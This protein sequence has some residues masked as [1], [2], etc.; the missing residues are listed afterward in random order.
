MRHLVLLALTPS[1]FH[2]SLGVNKSSL[3]LWAGYY[4]S[5]SGIRICGLVPFTVSTILGIAFFQE[6]QVLDRHSRVNLAAS[7]AELVV[8]ASFLLLRSEQGAGL[9]FF[10][11]LI[12]CYDIRF[13]GI[14]ELYIVY[15]PFPLSVDI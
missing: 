3:A 4:A 8:V 6:F 7:P 11:F 2:A 12:A 10:F 5:L 13:T 15:F 9:W 1:F 14:I